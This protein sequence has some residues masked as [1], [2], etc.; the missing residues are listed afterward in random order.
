LGR[1]KGLG[2]L[3]VNRIL[4]CW[5]VNE[6]KS[7]PSWHLIHFI[8]W[9]A[10]PFCQT[11]LEMLQDTIKCNKEKIVVQFLVLTMA[12]LYGNSNGHAQ[13]HH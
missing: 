1:K 4:G 10:H 9:L 7:T 2:P 11:L 12:N 5:R 6:K 3:G 13:M 8:F